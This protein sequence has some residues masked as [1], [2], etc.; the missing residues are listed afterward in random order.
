MTVAASAYAISIALVP[1][2]SNPDPIMPCDYFVLDVV[3]TDAGTPGVEVLNVEVS[4]NP[5]QVTGVSMSEGEFMAQQNPEMFMAFGYLIDNNAG[6][7]SYT[8][9]RLGPVSSTGAGTA[10]KL[11]F[12]C[13]ALGL[14]PLSYYAAATDALGDI[15][16]EGSGVIEVPQGEPAIPEPMTLALIG[17]ALTAL[18]VVAR[19]RS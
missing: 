9:T 2:P 10:A 8:I 5:A 14:T 13:E 18:G 7:M 4:Y 6:F 17:A 3:V 11:T 16:V 12:H 15:I 19:K 1:S